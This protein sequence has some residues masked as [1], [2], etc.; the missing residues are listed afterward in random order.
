MKKTW[1]KF[2][3]AALSAAMLVNSNVVTLAADD[4]VQTQSIVQEPQEE[5]KTSADTPAETVT[6]PAK[7]QT[8]SGESIAEEGKTDNKQ[9]AAKS[10]ETP[11]VDNGTAEKDTAAAQQTEKTAEDNKKDT[12]TATEPA[13][14]ET[15]AA[16]DKAFPSET[17]TDV[18]NDASASETSAPSK[19]VRR[20]RRALAQGEGVSLTTLADI[21]VSP[22]ELNQVSRT[23]TINFKAG[24]TIKKDEIDAAKSDTTWVYDLEDFVGTNNQP[25]KSVYSE[26]GG[27]GSIVS[28]TGGK[29]G[30]YEIKNNK[31]Y[32]YI[33]KEWLS[34]ITDDISGHFSFDAQLDA[35]RIGTDT[36]S[37]FTFPGV[38]HTTKIHY[39]NVELK[40]AAKEVSSNGGI[41]N[42]IASITKNSDGTYRLDYKIKVTPTANLNDLTLTDVIGGE[43][44]LDMNSFKIND[45]G[46]WTEYKVDN[47]N[48][49]VKV[50]KT[51]DGFSLDLAGYLKEK[52]SVVKAYKDYT[53]TYSTILTDEQM[54]DSASKINHASWTYN[55]GSTADGGNTNVTTKKD[56]KITKSV[57]E[58]PDKQSYTWTITLGD[59]NTDLSGASLKDVMTDT[60]KIL[61]DD[62][63]HIV[64]NTPNATDG[65]TERYIDDALASTATGPSYT[66]TFKNED[67]QLTK[68]GYTLPAGLG[69]GPYT[70]TYTTT[71]AVGDALTNWQ[72]EAGGNFQEWQQTTNKATVTKDGVT[73]T[74]TASTSHQYPKG[75]AGQEYFIEKSCDTDRTSEANAQN[76][77]NNVV[78]WTIKL[79]AGTNLD[80]DEYAAKYDGH[81]IYYVK[82]Y[83]N[84]GYGAAPTYS[85]G[86]VVDW[87][88]ITVERD[89]EGAL[90]PDNTPTNFDLPTIE[91]DQQRTDAIKITNL[92]GPILLHVATRTQKSGDQIIDDEFRSFYAQNKT[93][94][95][96]DN[97]W[98]WGEEKEAEYANEV[99]DYRMTKNGTYNKE[100]GTYTWEVVINPDKKVVSSNHPVYFE[101]TL[102]AGMKLVGNT[103]HV[104]FQ[105]GWWSEEDRQVTITDGDQQKINRINLSTEGDGTFKDG[106]QI[107]GNKIIITYKTELTQDEKDQLAKLAA[108]GEA[109]P[110]KTYT[111]EAR[112]YAD[113]TDESLVHTATS[114]VKSQYD[115][116]IK[117]DQSAKT[118]GDSDYISYQIIVNKDAVQLNNGGL[119]IL[120]DRIDTNVELDTSSVKITDKDGAALSGCAISYSDSTRILTVKIPDSTYAKVTYDVR[121]RDI[122]EQTFKNS[123]TLKGAK[124]YNDSVSEQ[125][126]VG[127]HGAD[128][129]GSNH[130]LTLIKFDED[131][132]TKKLSGA[133][134]DLYECTLKS[135]NTIDKSTK[136]NNDQQPYETGN[137]GTVTITGL[138]YKKLYYWQEVDAPSGYSAETE[139]DNDNTTDPRK[140]YFIMYE[141]Q[142][143]RQSVWDMDDAVQKANGITVASIPDGHIWN[144]SNKKNN[145]SGSISIK[146]FI[147]GNAYG[148]NQ[149]FLFT[150]K[151][152]DSDNKGVNG[153]YN[154]TIKTP[155]EQDDGTAKDN[156]QNIILTFVNGT[157]SLKLK[158]NQTA[159][160]SGIPARYQYTVKELDNSG[161]TTINAASDVKT[162]AVDK[163]AAGTITKNQTA[164]IEYTNTLDS[165]GELE[166]SKTVEGNAL[167]EDDS[168]KAYK[169]TVKLEL[170][171]GS[172]NSATSLKVADITKD[173]ATP[174]ASNLPNTPDNLTAGTDYYDS[175]HKTVTLYVVPGHTKKI[176]QIPN[177]TA[178]EVTEDSASGAGFETSATGTGTVE[179]ATTD[180]LVSISGK[181][182]EDKVQKA[183]FVNT[184]NTYGDLQISKTVRG[185]NK[186]SDFTFRV[187]LLDEENGIPLTGTYTVKTVS[188]TGDS[189]TS[190]EEKTLASDG[191]LELK[192]K[193]GQSAVI[194]ALPNGTWYSVSEVPAEGF[195]QVS[196]NR[197]ATSDFA[198]GSIDGYKN[199]KG[200]TID[201]SKKQ[202]E[203]AF[204]NKD[205]SKGDLVVEK[206]VEGNAADTTT[207][208]Q[209]KVTLTSG[210]TESDIQGKGF[211]KVTA[212]IDGEQKTIYSCEFD[213]KNGE[214]KRFT[215]LPDGA[216]YTVEE[217]VNTATDAQD[218]SVQ[219]YSTTVTTTKGTPGEPAVKSSVTGTISKDYTG[220]NAIVEHFTNTKNLYGGFSI[221]KVLAGTDVA[222]YNGEF[223]FKVTVYGLQGDTV[224]NTSKVPATEADNGTITFKPENG[225]A[226][227]ESIV[228]KGG[229]KFSVTGLPNG[230]TYSVEE[231]LPEQ[232]KDKAQ[233][234]STSTNATNVVIKGTSANEATCTVDSSNETKFTNT[235]NAVGSLAI[236]KV[237][238]GNSVP[239]NDSTYKINVTLTAPSG[240][241]TSNE[242]ALQLPVSLPGQQSKQPVDF[243]KDPNNNNVF[244]HVFVIIGQG[245]IKIHQIPAGMSYTVSEEVP[246]GAAFTST[247]TGKDGTIE[248][249]QEKAATVTN[250]YNQ[251]GGFKISKTV[252]GNDPDYRS[253]FAF[254]VTLSDKSINGVYGNIAFKN[255]VSVKD[256][257]SDN[258]AIQEIA[259][260]AVNPKVSDAELPDGYI[261]V[262]PDNA[263]KSNIRYAAGLPAGVTFQVEEMNYSG[264]YDTAQTSPN[265]SKIQGVANTKNGVT[266]ANI[267]D[268]N[269]VSFTNTRNRYGKLVLQKIITGNAASPDDTFTFTLTP[270][271]EHK[272]SLK[273]QTFSGVTFDQN[274]GIATVTIKGAPFADGK[275]EGDIKKDTYR[276]AGGIVK[277]I[278]GFPV[279]VKLT[280]K[281]IQ[282]DYDAVKYILTSNESS[283]AY[284][285]EPQAKIE[286][287]NP[288][289]VTAINTKNRYG[290]IKVKKIVD[291]NAVDPNAEFQFTVKL[292]NISLSDENKLTINNEYIK[293]TPDAEGN[294]YAWSFTLKKDEEKLLKGIPNGTPYTIT[295]TTKKD[296]GYVTTSSTGKVTTSKDRENQVST[297]SGIVKGTANTAD[298]VKNADPANVVTITNTINKTGKISLQ[299]VVDGNDP[300]GGTFVFEVD[301]K[302]KDTNKPFTGNV[303]ASNPEETIR[304]ANGK[305]YVQIKSG[306]SRVLD[307]LPN[308]AKVTVKETDESKAGYESVSYQV[309]N[310]QKETEDQTANPKPD[311]ANA[312]VV[313]SN[314]T[315]NAVKICNTHNTYGYLSIKKAVD[316]ENVKPEQEFTFRVYLTNPDGTRYVPKNKKITFNIKADGTQDKTQE[317]SYADNL[318]DPLKLKAGETAVL[319]DDSKLPNGVRYVVN[320]I[321][322]PDGYA[323]TSN[324]HLTGNIEGGKT[325]DLTFR[326]KQI[327]VH[328]S[329]VDIT[330]EEEVAGAHLQVLE[331]GDDGEL[332]VVQEWDSKVTENGKGHAITGLKVG[333]Q[334]TL[335]ET[336]APDGYAVTTDTTFQLKQDG[337]F[338][339]EGTTTP[340][341]SDG[342]LLVK[343]AKTSVRISKV[344]ITSQEELAGAHIQIID[345][346]TLK[347]VKIDD[348]EVEWNSTKKAHEVTGLATGKTYILRETVAPKGYTVTSDTEFK[349][350]A[351]GSLDTDN[352]TTK[353]SDDGRLLVEDSMTSITISKREINGSE[354]IEGARLQ[355]IDAETND[356]KKEWVSQKNGGEVIT[357]LSVGKDEKGKEYILRETIA[358]NGY[359]AITDTPF[360]LKP[361]GTIEVGKDQTALSLVDGT[362]VVEDNFATGS[363]SITKHSEN[364]NGKKLKGCSYLL[365][366]KMTV[367]KGRVVSRKL[368]DKEYYYTGVDKQG[369]A[370]WTDDKEKALKSDGLLIT[371][372]SGTATATGLVM[373]DYY[374]LEQIAPEAHQVDTKPI[375]VKVTDENVKNGGEQAETVAANQADQMTSVRIS[376]VDATTQ[377]ELEGAHIQIIDK[378]TGKV[379][380]EWDSTK[381][382]HEVKGLTQDKEYILRETTAPEGYTL[383]SDTTFTVDQNNKVTST[384]ST[385]KDKNGNTILLVEDTKTSVKISKVDVTNGKELKGAHI[386]IIDKE[387]G[388]VVEEWVSTTK[389]HEVA[390]LTTG[391][392]YILRETVAP[393]GYDITTDTEFTLD[394]YGKISG[395]A[396]VKNGVILVQDA[397]KK[398][399]EKTTGASKPSKT[400]KAGGAKTGDTAP[401]TA[402]AGILSV[403]V[404]ALAILI[405]RRKYTK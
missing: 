203:A 299:K 260:N 99:K 16:T 59:E 91:K 208:F 297:V 307:G 26:K 195:E 357:G 151:L 219:G 105:G 98:S 352:T 47:Q 236:N 119:L 172:D 80:A 55:G 329:K 106:K 306:T 82:D 402:A 261:I 200:V 256:T 214:Q 159:E 240:S 229:E 174:A 345:K 10:D 270:D 142:N 97:D 112:E 134:F 4:A 52:G 64:L 344:D 53:I 305:A 374:F 268:D 176:S 102:P 262:F 271:D 148:P 232:E 365:A 78:Y 312:S 120:T 258:A 217:V 250:T 147:A 137:D 163:T 224:C 361:N 235:R 144:V 183:D 191:S 88:N 287:N 339:T 316:G 259:K 355:I 285:K 115:A 381:E 215:G 156:E 68:D 397:K 71:V 129:T 324:N 375:E 9:P 198:S 369:Q 231:I 239:Q 211:T 241:S 367:K 29:A 380:E 145:D 388:K 330:S 322:I 28:P 164:Q 274:T 295:E 1:K 76:Q 254:K 210:V 220:S 12:V 67:K 304:F 181:I 272:E 62:D 179:A 51:D 368:T 34:D 186:G 255:G 226:T 84:Y 233:F 149:E 252:D 139:K 310:G 248:Q 311:S 353:I 20:P 86:L 109:D 184:K 342:R 170:P 60:Q 157:A 175:T 323:L 15:T 337:S 61:V 301:V 89:S 173:A 22:D 11:T 277:V 400:S 242:N 33:D 221:E 404:L 293:G 66:G 238:T 113:E 168:T 227:D 138:D 396:T 275:S 257:R 343:D 189:Q 13:K 315:T 363:V 3:A 27:S 116:L 178:Y 143:D 140:W 319:A 37:S 228:L 177:G 387:T 212:T 390:G 213:L 44:T 280:V 360:T 152:T 371:D 392:T 348:K 14:T 234:L 40:N 318:Y 247:I 146:K 96:I 394:Q 303:K 7:E 383:T 317:L 328:I 31:V 128:I 93:A 282:S 165:Y 50:K 77:D 126:N 123:A 351:D 161:T 349:L 372:D 245:Q 223:K 107:S 281:E 399:A 154:C 23:Q 193:D 43:Q 32:L 132:L 243:Q 17:K 160:I 21:T 73:S 117:T 320:E 401:I 48:D 384:G 194:E 150:V 87:D 166:I 346:E 334:Y 338:Y 251:F 395:T 141:N 54:A 187:K 340:I 249:D 204:I 291:G 114:E 253:W 196:V 118:L 222:G 350:K 278:E 111:N 265:N 18:Q 8:N 202:K 72:D 209:F 180:H 122:G 289:I 237:V 41:Q 335:R 266:E 385:T 267:S 276:N 167:A 376:K 171:V 19:T 273:G 230:A 185:N 216:E 39:E 85:T 121:A 6:E 325:T 377:K 110:T 153:D 358:P 370:T 45:T 5:E 92:R 169:F 393:E 127:G 225:V 35:D 42:N 244:S 331:K 296:D 341:A 264:I 403:A 207:P 405:R 294:T 333:R 83:G 364:M 130:S 308:G 2:L 95:S 74:A 57:T 90:Y 382:A 327:I 70:I 279:G 65:K 36:D 101:D 46:C 354:E 362:L 58:S 197:E 155:V 356:V 389:A 336:V 286:E 103:I 108:K 288:K 246:N 158:G 100:D 283:Q 292:Q 182:S 135:D 69:K 309:N 379:V 136:V 386:Q 131:D 24:F 398:A 314:T 75:T 302:E 218:D 104:I 124:V 284:A 63:H 133:K 192:L 81:K 269:I 30:T 190:S 201:T 25:I 56:I 94:L 79:N 298:T 326:N 313:V 199:A 332:K 347:V 359:T 378:E 300:I 321:S 205:T 162:N 125:H 290:A 188:A 373:G 391:K 263:D 49:K 206:S 38:D 366:T